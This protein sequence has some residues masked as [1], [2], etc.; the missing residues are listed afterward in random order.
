M[1]THPIKYTIYNI[2]I[3]FML[4]IITIHLFGKN[5]IRFYDFFSKYTV[6]NV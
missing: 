4:F 5:S 2:K 6:Y 3:K 1:Y